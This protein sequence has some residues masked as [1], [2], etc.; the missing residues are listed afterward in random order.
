L[1]EHTILKLLTRDT[2]YF[3]KYIGI[4]ESVSMETENKLILNLIKTYYQKFPEHNYISQAE[5][6]SYFASEYKA[7][8]DPTNILQMIDKIYE[9]DTSDSLASD[10]VGRLVE[11]DVANNVINAL[12]P[13]LQGESY[14]QL[15]KATD[16][17]TEWQELEFGVEEDESPFVDAS[18]AELLEHND[19]DGLRFRLDCVNEALG[20]LTGGTL[21]HVFARPEVGKTTFA[22]SEATFFVE[23]VPT[24]SCV[25]WINNEEEGEKVRIRQHSAMTGMTKAAMAADTETAERVFNER[26]GSRLR[27]YDNAS[28][29][30]TDIERL[31][32][33]YQPRIV[34]IDQGD[35]ITYR[36]QDKAGNGADRL[37][38]VYDKLR[39]VVKRCNKQ[40]KMD[41]ITIGQADAQ[42]E[43]RKWLNLSNLDS[44]KT[45]KAGAFDYVIGIG[46]TF[47]ED[48]ESVR[49]IS[50]AKNKLGGKHS[51]V[52]VTIDSEKARYH[53]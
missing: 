29:S 13:T 31:C 18:L 19:T 28:V 51:K 33:E 8:R 23:Q 26:G 30:I 24:D 11:Q 49:Y 7:H 47:I 21:G 34:F 52:R 43:G 38:Q 45:G 1:I 42:C 48:E 50:F 5:L 4:I 20:P 16:M 6:N 15:M 17:I 40:W 3:N 25:L 37:K 27:L 36:G 10:I 53:D 22:H 46:K 35:K 41:I 14:G 2:Q 12:L 44:G 32:K 9:V 39:E